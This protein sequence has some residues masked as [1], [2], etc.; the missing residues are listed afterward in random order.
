PHLGASTV[1][2]QRSV[3]IEAAQLLVDYLKRGVVQFAVNMAAVDKAELQ[4]LKHY[5]DMARRL[6]LL[7]AQLDQGGTRRVTLHYRGDV[8]DRNTKLLTAAFAAGLLETRL[9]ENVNIVNA[10]LLARERGIE[11]VE[12]KNRDK[13]D[14]ST[15]IRA[16][17]QTDKDT[18]IAAA[19][20]F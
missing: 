10:E 15:L 11:I 16:E 9:A 20:L 2:A 3:A 14:F 17:V 1:E 7:H 18:Y 5:L 8:A 19:T 12:Q 4:E 13:G 6:G